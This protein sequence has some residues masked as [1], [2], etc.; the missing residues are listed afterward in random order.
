M[1]FGGGSP[2]PPAAPQAAPEAQDKG[3]VDARDSERRRR[4]LAAGNT[5]FT[6]PSGVP[7]PALLQTKTL[8]GQ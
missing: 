8:L 7:A 6:G 2:S 4:Q 3:V 1:C 5:N